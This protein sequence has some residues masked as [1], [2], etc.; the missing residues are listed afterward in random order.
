MEFNGEATGSFSLGCTPSGDQRQ[1]PC[2]PLSYS[3]KLALPPPHL[4]AVMAFTLNAHSF[5][6]AEISRWEGGG[7]ERG[8][9]SPRLHSA[10]DTNPR[11][12][13]RPLRFCLVLRFPSR[14]LSSQRAS[15]LAS[16]LSH[17]EQRLEAPRR[18]ILR[19]LPSGLR[20]WVFQVLVPW[21]GVSRKAGRVGRAPD[22][23][24]SLGFLW[25]DLKKNQGKF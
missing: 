19:L 24:G 15:R 25:F 8:S 16:R 10:I 9:D 14:A 4:R 18:V 22:V 21:S 13:L 7:P 11:K 3:L 1:N 12:Q 23:G 2:H 5:R 6:V 17:G 20:Y